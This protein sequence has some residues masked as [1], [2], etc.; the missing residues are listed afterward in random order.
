M[1]QAVSVSELPDSL[2]AE[3]NQLVADSP[4]G[5]IY[6]MPEYLD[7]L[8]RATGGHFRILGAFRGADLVGG[9][10]VYE[11]Q[12]PYGIAIENRL[13]LYY[14]GIVLRGN[15][16]RHTAETLSRRATVVS[17]LVAYLEQHPYAKITLHCRGLYDA[18]PMLSDGWAVRPSY[19]YVVPTENI[20]TS[21]QRMDQNVRRLIKRAQTNGL[22]V[23]DDDDFEAFFQMHSQVHA[24]KGA[25]IY[26]SATV[27]RQYFQALKGAGFCSLLQV[28]L[29]SGR[30]IAAQLVLLGPHPIS[31][32]VCAAADD[33]FMKL[34][35]TPLLRWEAFKRLAQLG[36]AGNDL[37][38]ASLNSVTR[39]KSQLGGDLVMNI[40]ATRPESLKV[41]VAEH[42]LPTWHRM[43]A[44]IAI[45]SNL[46]RLYGVR[47][48]RLR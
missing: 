9:I 33:G 6:S 45:R 11:E 43:R 44:S 39:F 4:E 23:T 15:D 17:A 37:T 47:A 42:I 3:W 25:P 48:H 28:R 30:P 13:L 26:L 10:A 41:R 40:I 12:R 16:G 27:F 31:H 8:C 29:P 34:G 19:T 35:S 22:T 21:W 1:S 7:V 5:S 32:T 20:E 2:R 14:N 46:R 24:R 18:R 38:D 36:Y